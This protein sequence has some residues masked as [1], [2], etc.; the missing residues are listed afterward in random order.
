MLYCSEACEVIAKLC[1][2]NRFGV[3]LD[4]AAFSHARASLALIVFALACYLPGFFTLPPIDR[5]EAWFAQGSK[6]MLESRDFIT[7][8]FQASPRLNKPVGIYW[9]QAATVRL[10]ESAGFAGARNCI[11]L[12]RIPSLIGA[13]ASVLLLYWTG[14][15]FLS[16][17]GAILAAALLASCLLIGVEARLAKTDATLLATVMAAQGS[18]AH[19][20]M[21]A[22]RKRP[23]HAGWL[24][25]ILCISVAIGLL[26]KGPLILLF[27]FTTALV[28][29]VQFG[30]A[31]WL[32]PLRPLIGLAVAL[33]LVMPWYI[34]IV[35]L[36]GVM[37]AKATAHDLLGKI[38]EIQEGHWGPPGYHFIGLWIAFWP[39]T[40]LLIL[41]LPAIWRHRHE[42][43]RRF[44]LAWL[45]PCWLLFEII[46]TKLPHYV[47]PL[48]P[49]IALLLAI[50]LE[51]GQIRLPEG[52]WRWT[53]L[54]WWPG[55]ALGLTSFAMLGYTWFEGGLPWAFMPPMLVAVIFG[56]MALGRRELDGLGNS[57]ALALATASVV[58]MVT[59]GLLVPSTRHLFPAQELISTIRK[60]PCAEPELAVIGFQEPSLVFLGGTHLRI[61]D[62]ADGVDFL[63]SHGC[64][65]LILESR[66][67]VNFQRVAAIA[68]LRPQFLGQV[69]G[70][71]FSKGRKV[72]FTLLTP[73]SLIP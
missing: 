2:C 56:F 53:L 23:Y 13:V 55:M 69:G 47:L 54:W 35:S 9:L 62:A 30:S 10:A 20:W 44:L 6:Q 48:Y 73:I 16:R 61:I 46:A 59:F 1:C 32:Q 40:P 66:E 70:V 12:Y 45:L 72:D 37:F 18:L 27:C 51:E 52:G 34:A 11:A 3:L 65:V 41:S 50:S 4:W 68:G 22:Q 31:S 33:L 14:L 42:P 63:S 8:R 24:P 49:A 60:L 17:R 7:P 58:Y 64:R 25:V 43:R 19:A 28:V 5:D 67:A 57:V 39:A 15:A 26:I 36:D 38:T 71:N 29:S 21:Q